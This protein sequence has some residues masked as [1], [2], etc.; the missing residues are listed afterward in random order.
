MAIQWTEDLSV[1]V[2]QID[3]QHKELFNRVNNLLE[4]CSKGRGRDIVQET[5]EFL[6]DYTITHFSTEERHMATHGYP[7]FKDH[8]AQ[9]ENFIE[10]FIS[11]KKRVQEEGPGGHIVIE[12]NRTIVTWLN[13]HIRNVDKKLGEFLKDKGI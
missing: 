2:T 8:K 7:E 5:I 4:A 13:S 12:T 6:G 11:L 9:H 3:K 1:G 10:H